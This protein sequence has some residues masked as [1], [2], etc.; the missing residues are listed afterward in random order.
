M[1][2]GWRALRRCPPPIAIFARSFSRSTTRPS[3]ARRA[4]PRPLGSRSATSRS[5][6][7]CVTRRLAWSAAITP[8][9]SIR[10]CFSWR[11][12]PGVAHVR[13]SRSSS[14]DISMAATRCGGALSAWG[15][16]TGRAVLWTLPRLCTAERTGRAQAAWTGRRGRRPAHSAHRHHF[17]ESGQI[18]CQTEADRSLVNNSAEAERAEAERAEAEHRRE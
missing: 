4:I 11:S 2:C 7:F 16:L 9:P 5:I 12:S 8:W 10:W 3:G 17:S 18:T 15:Y 1:S 13:A 14:A 6:R